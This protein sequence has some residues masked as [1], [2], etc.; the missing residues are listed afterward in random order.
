MRPRGRF[1]S[2][3]KGVLLTR[4]AK[5][6]WFTL[7]FNVLVIL[8]GALVRATGSGAG[9]GR[10]W[11]DCQGAWV[12]LSPTLETLIEFTHRATS[13]LALVLVLVL[14]VWA[15][16]AFPRG[17]PVRAGAWAS[18]AFIVVEALVGAGLVLFELVAENS[19]AARAVVI[20]LH[21]AN[22]LLLLGALALTA[23]WAGGGAALR[24]REHGKLSGAWGLGA[25]LLLGLGA[26]GAVT[27]LGD[28]LF[29]AGSLAEGLRQDVSPT[30]HFLVT[31]RV[32]HPLLAVASGAFLLPAAR[33]MGQTQPSARR[34]ARW[35][36]GLFAL[37]LG[38]GALNLALLAPLPLQLVHLLVADGLW[39]AYVL[40]GAAALAARPAA[41]APR[42][43]PTASLSGAGR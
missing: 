14:V 25:S 20:A 6:A 42:S 2:P 40:L 8:W 33:W 30:A 1:R 13:G 18:L 9:C 34:P 24:P 17:A 31:L 29:P 3:P 38:L 12:P 28:T 19:S 16:R 37:Q 23:W 27:A 36:M 39:I 43:T 21:L 7:F 5:Y 15:V 26:T 41:R 35:V 11:P 10:H 4:F 22:T 32:W